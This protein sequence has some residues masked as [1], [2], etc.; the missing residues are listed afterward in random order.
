MFKW[1]EIGIS[2]IKVLMNKYLIVD[3]IFVLTN[4]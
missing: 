4:Y 2:Y 3:S 1:K